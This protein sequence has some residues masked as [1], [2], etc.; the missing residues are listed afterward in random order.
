M[1]L[2]EIL[3][4]QTPEGKLPYREWFLS[5]KEASVRARIRARIDRLQLGNWGDFESVGEGVLELRL[6]FGPGYRIYFAQ[7]GKKL[8]LLLCG[9]DK[10]TQDKDIKLAQ[11]YGHDYKRRK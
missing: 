1:D 8:I 9:G 3:Q 5:L 4:Y 6:H 2:C 7:D 10:S 11:Q